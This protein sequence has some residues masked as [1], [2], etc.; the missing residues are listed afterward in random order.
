MKVSKIFG[1]VLCVALVIVFSG[2]TLSAK[3][4]GFIDLKLTESQVK[5]LTPVSE[6]YTRKQSIVKKRIEKIEDDMVENLR[7]EDRFSSETLHRIRISRFNM[8]LKSLGNVHGELL[9]VRVGF[10]VKAR[11]ILTKEQMKLLMHTILDSIEDVVEFDDDEI[12][13][14]DLTD[15]DW[16]I[17]LTISQER[18]LID[19]YAH[20]DIQRIRLIL[21]LEHQLL[22]IE[23]LIL[24]GAR[25]SAAAD[26]RITEIGEIAARVVDNE[27]QAFIVTKDILT[28]PQ[29]KEMLMKILLSTN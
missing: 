15:P 26:D 10:L 2:T 13:G 6:D 3:S 7:K 12:L 24:S 28:I 22:D 27:V 8:L 4:K 29:K 20:R 17:D 21:A 25:I 9:K 1:L 14:I 16:D 5:K 18:T 23:E 19:Y 11:N